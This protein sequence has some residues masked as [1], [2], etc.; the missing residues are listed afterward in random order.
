MDRVAQ[1]EERS[2]SGIFGF[3]AQDYSLQE[4]MGPIQ[5]HAAERLLPTDKAIVMARRMLNEAALGLEQE[6]PLPPLTQ[7][8]STCGPQACYCPAI[9]TRWPGPARSWQTRRR[10]RSSA[11]EQETPRREMTET[12]S[13]EVPHDTQGRPSRRRLHGDCGANQ[14][15]APSNGAPPSPYASSCPLRAVRMMYWR[16]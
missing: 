8:S 15:T 5:D 12:K 7:A 16:A 9:R 3:S 11:F 4:S 6:K 1:R 14:A 2:Y 10:S 13:N